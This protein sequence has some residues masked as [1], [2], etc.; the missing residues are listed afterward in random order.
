[1]PEITIASTT[2]YES[3]NNICQASNIC[4]F[5]QPFNPET[6]ML[7]FSGGINSSKAYSRYWNDLVFFHTI[8]TW[9]YGIDINN[10]KV[11]Y[12]DG[13]AENG[14]LPV[15][16]AANP[17]GITDAFDFLKKRWTLTTPL[18]FSRLI[19]AEPD[20]PAQFLTT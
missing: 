8:M 1:M 9:Y 5:I 2:I 4:D 18:F 7:L 15:H 11:V 3:F 12:K 20:I 17:T 6:Y 10:I 19:T 13:T 16:Y 14:F